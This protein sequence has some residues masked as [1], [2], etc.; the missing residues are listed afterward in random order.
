MGTRGLWV[1]S[2]WLWTQG[3]RRPQ[4]RLRNSLHT[5]PWATRFRRGFWKL[6]NTGVQEVEGSP[7]METCIARVGDN[8]ISSPRKS[9][10]C[11]C[12]KKL[13][14]R[15]VCTGHPTAL[16]PQAAAPLSP[17]ECFV[18]ITVGSTL[19]G[20]MVT[21]GPWQLVLSWPFPR[22]DPCSSWKRLPSAAAGPRQSSSCLPGC[23]F[24][25]L[26]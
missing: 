8:V 9:S 10:C 7:V 6:L 24:S 16:L 22:A 13:L 15:M 23:S 11:H 1:S 2:R 18:T 17:Q 26:C 4:G 12:R 20:T 3:S 14:E 5:S 25:G 19:L 21:P